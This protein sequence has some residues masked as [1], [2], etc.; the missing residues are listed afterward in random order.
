M[1]KTDVVWRK[2]LDLYELPEGRVKAVT[3]EHRTLSV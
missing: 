2:A 3:C 1:S